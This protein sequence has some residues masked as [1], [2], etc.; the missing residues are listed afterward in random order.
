MKL[1]KLLFWIVL[2]HIVYIFF[3]IEGIGPWGYV[4]VLF[5][6]IEK[7]QM[8][9]PFVLSLLCKSLSATLHYNLPLRTDVIK[10]CTSV[11]WIYR[12]FERRWTAEIKIWNS[13]SLVCR[14]ACR[15]TGRLNIIFI[16]KSLNWGLVPFWIMSIQEV[17]LQNVWVIVKMNN[18][19]LFWN[20]FKL[21]KHGFWK[22][23]QDHLIL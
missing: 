15:R 22:Y 23:L 20:S 9:G 11:I 6:C 18:E 12:R 10:Q 3:H 1:I 2:F 5:I 4:L 13:E 8:R 7:T 16:I 14:C 21:V 19:K 17:L